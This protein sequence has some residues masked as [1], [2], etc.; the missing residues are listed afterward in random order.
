MGQH[1][2]EPDGFAVEPKDVRIQLLQLLEHFLDPRATIGLAALF[3][4][5]AQHHHVIG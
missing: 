2:G 3:P 1:F 4:D 5:L